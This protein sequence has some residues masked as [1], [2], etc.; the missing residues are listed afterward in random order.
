M[1]AGDIT[2]IGDQPHPVGGLFMWI[3]TCEL[4]DAGT[5][6]ELGDKIRLVNVDLI[7]ADDAE[8]VRVVLNSDDGTAD[9]QDGSFWAYHTGDGV[10]TYDMRAY[11]I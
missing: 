10:K 9:T 4:D 6:F 1:A 7:G 2:L 8:S 3:G 11:G 5:E